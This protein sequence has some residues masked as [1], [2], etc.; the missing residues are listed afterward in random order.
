MISISFLEDTYR[1]SIID[2][3]LDHASDIAIVY[4]NVAVEVVPDHKD[5]RRFVHIMQ[6]YWPRFIQALRRSQPRH[7]KLAFW[8]L[9]ATSFKLKEIHEFPP[10]YRFRFQGQKPCYLDGCLCSG[11]KPKHP[12]RVCKGCWHAYYCSVKCQTL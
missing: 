4:N 1:A 8:E 2:Q 10:E 3:Y 7:A 12:M 6:L 9:M 5:R 11:M